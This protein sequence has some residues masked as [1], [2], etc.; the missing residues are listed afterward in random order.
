MA[1]VKLNLCGQLF[2]IIFIITQLVFL[3]SKRS[4]WRAGVA[5]LED[6]YYLFKTPLLC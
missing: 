3:V 6:V 2:R 1:S 4:F 5:S